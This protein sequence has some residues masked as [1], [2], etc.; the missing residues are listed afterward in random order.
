MAGF[1]LPG[2]Y[3]MCN[4]FILSSVSVLYLGVHSV[5]GLHEMK[6]NFQALKDLSFLGGEVSIDC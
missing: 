4:E 6:I 3:S 5:G 1:I 2:G